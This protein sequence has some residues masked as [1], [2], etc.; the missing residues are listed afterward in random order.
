MFRKERKSFLFFVIFIMTGFIFFTSCAGPESPGSTNASFVIRID[1]NAIN[2]GATI[3]FGNTPIGKSIDKILIIE[4]AGTSEEGVWGEYTQFFGQDFSLINFDTSKTIIIGAGQSISSII[5]FSPTTTDIK[6]AKLI[7]KGEGYAIDFFITGQGSVSTTTTVKV[8]T[9]TTTTTTVANTTTTLAGNASMY[10]RGSFNSWD[11]SIPMALVAANEWEATVNLPVSDITFKFDAYGDWASSSNWG[12]NNA[13]GTAGLGEANIV[14][15]II[16]GGN[17][18]FRFNDST[19]LY[20]II[21]PSATTTTA[22]T[23]TTINSTTTTTVPNYSIS[24]N[25]NDASATGT[26]TAQTGAAGSNVTLKACSFTKT[27]Y[28]FAGWAT[29]TSGSVVYSNQATYAIGASNVTL[30]AKWT[31]KTF[32]VTFNSQGGSVV[33]SQTINYNGLVTQPSAPTK[34]G[35]VFGGWYKESTYINA[36]NFSTD[37]ITAA[38]TL[39]AKWNVNYTVTFN[40]QG[41][42]AVSSQ[43]VASGSLLTEPAAP[44]NSFYTFNGWYKEST[45]VNKWNFSSDTVTSSITLYAKW[46]LPAPTNVEATLGTYLD[47]V[48]ITW[49]GVPTSSGY[50]VYRSTEAAGTFTKIYTINDS[51]SSYDDTTANPGVDYYYKVSATGGGILSSEAKGYRKMPAP[52][53]VTASQGTSFSSVTVSWSS[54]SG[55]SMYVLKRSTS[56]GGA[57]LI[58]DYVLETSYSDTYPDGYPN[59]TYYYKVSARGDNN[60]EGDYSTPVSGYAK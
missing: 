34:S 48:T 50:E 16:A 25:K 57:Y 6:N 33:S 52:A 20:T 54:V 30:Y 9:T 45:Y 32:T 26:M 37:R 13:D 27:G 58:V 46:S 55:T 10:L 5:R 41:G 4:N 47:K 56:S 17:T 40:S 24:F 49:G 12:D 31:I 60:I 43:T 8:A 14:Y 38:T 36:W 35:S 42:S 29:T 21:E 59:T 39:Y 15:T 19:L 11:T 22:T 3:S 18:T 53:G 23:T 28:N 7:F 1:G 51:I 2:S 44:T